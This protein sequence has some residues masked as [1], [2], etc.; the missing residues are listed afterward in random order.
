MAKA[1]IKN[2]LGG[3]PDDEPYYIDRYALSMW[4]LDSHKQ[5]EKANRLLSLYRESTG[6]DIS[7]FEQL[8]IM[9]E[10]VS[11]YIRAEYSRINQ[12]EFNKL[13]RLKLKLADSIDID[14]IC[15]GKLD[16]LKQ[17]A[18]SFKSYLK[19]K[20]EYFTIVDGKV[21]LSELATTI[22]DNRT[23]F[24]ARTAQEK[25]RLKI[26]MD[27]IQALQQIEDDFKENVKPTIA[28]KIIADKSYLL[29]KIPHPITVYQ[30]TLIPNRHWIENG[31]AGVKGLGVYIPTQS[32][33]ERAKRDAE[34]IEA[35]RA[36]PAPETIWASGPLAPSAE[37]FNE[38]L[39][40]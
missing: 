17:A 38:A 6:F 9:A 36:K 30:G 37:A 24:Y 19:F 5:L 2:L 22:R 1:T 25:K 35:R 12:D 33:I 13:T 29:G 20:P 18:A 15:N 26:S 23:K 21:Q 7:V 34:K 39:T 16:D 8:I 14:S 32:E 28:N 40:K 31:F 11:D 4:E 10:N 3:K 27:I